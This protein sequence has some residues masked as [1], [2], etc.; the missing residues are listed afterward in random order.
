MGSD[1]DSVVLTDAG[2]IAPFAGL[3]NVDFTACFVEGISALGVGSGNLS[4][5]FTANAL[6]KVTVTYTF[7]PTGIDIEKATNDEDAD[8]APGPSIPVGDPVNWTYVV[9]NTGEA[10]LI[11]I[12][13]V[14]DQGVLVMCP[15]TMLVSLDSMI[16]TANG[17]AAAGPYENMGTATGQ[18]V[19][20]GDTPLGG[21]IDDTDPS[22]YTGV[23]TT[24]DIEKATN[25]VDAD[26]PPGPSIPVG[27]PVDWTYVVTNT[28][29]AKLID[30]VVTDDQGVLVICPETMLVPADSMIC[31]AAGIAAAGQY[32]N[33]GETV[34][35]PV[36]DGD[37]PIG[38]PVMDTDPSHYFGTEVCDPKKGKKG[39][40]NKNKYR[41]PHG[42]SGGYVKWQ[43]HWYPVKFKSGKWFV[44]IK[45]VKRSVRA[46]GGKRF[47]KIE[48]RRYGVKQGTGSRKVSKGNGSKCDP[49]KDKKDKDKKGGKDPKDGKGPK[50]GKDPKP[51]VGRNAE[52]WEL[53][54]PAAK[55]T[56]FF[57]SGRA[58][59]KVLRKRAGR[60]YFKLAH[61]YIAAKLSI[62]AGAS[63]TSEVD[64]A[65]AWAER[66]FTKHRP[67]H[68]SMRRAL[69]IEEAR[70]Q[71]VKIR[72]IKRLRGAMVR[73]AKTLRAFGGLPRCSA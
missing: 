59:V 44:K 54:G 48:G 16:C 14:D 4:L 56:T 32:A 28:G 50:V 51:T 37:S 68:T 26:A 31:T 13:V 42:G 27:D 10:K 41:P 5:D 52:A 2:D 22:H 11:D 70:T 8:L 1:D 46:R 65:V 39:K 64:E 21:P 33:V 9:T 29:D 23:A 45:G 49:K 60:P 63:T 7:V 30:I 71:Q 58:Y 12:V 20:D 47:V 62:L 43:Q 17:I 66:Y 69:K 34:G 38:D 25:G 67:N 15:E 53:L 61:A 73:H 35:Q 72:K 36:D 19:D 18:P 3:G 40:K 6:V 57:G 24:I 55:K